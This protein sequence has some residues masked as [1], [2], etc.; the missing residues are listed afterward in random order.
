MPSL[1]QLIAEDKR[2]TDDEALW[3]K[4]SGF[5]GHVVEFLRTSGFREAGPRNNPDRTSTATFLR[6]THYPHIHIPVEPTDDLDD[7]LTAIYDAGYTDGSDRI[8]TAHQK[9]IEAVQRPRRPSATERSI[10]QRLAALE[11]ENA[12]LNKQLGKLTLP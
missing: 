7:V 12:R 4:A 6:Q 10:E 5:K 9:F 11:S 2:M 3:L 1:S 8:A